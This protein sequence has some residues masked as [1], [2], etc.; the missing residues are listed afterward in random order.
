LGR[1]FVGNASTSDTIFTLVA[2]RAFMS[3]WPGSI[4]INA[5]IPCYFPRKT[6]INGKVD[7]HQLLD[8]EL[9]DILNLAKKPN[10][11]ITM[12][13]A[14][15]DPYDYYLHCLNEYL[16]KLANSNHYACEAFRNYQR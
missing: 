4:K 12:L 1:A 3:S 10:W 13:K 7:C 16:K 9:C 15:Q 14:N 8:D 5:C 11:T 2:N 6:G